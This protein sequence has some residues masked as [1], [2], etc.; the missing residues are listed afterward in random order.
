MKCSFLLGSLFAGLMLLLPAIA[1]AGYLAVNVQYGSLN[2]SDN[3]SA[4]S[5]MAGLAGPSADTGKVWNSLN[6]G[7]AYIGLVTTNPLALVDS[8][9]ASTSI[10][11]SCSVPDGNGNPGT[12]TLPLFRSALFNN[13]GFDEVFTLSGLNS[14]DRYD[15]VQSRFA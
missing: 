2:N 10:K 14:S 11:F 15:R 5:S 9:G 8:T 1:S 6:A 13:T 4:T 12:G 3:Q 7:K